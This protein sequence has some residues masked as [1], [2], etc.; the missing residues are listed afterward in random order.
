MS[1]LEVAAERAAKVLPEA[2]AALVTDYLWDVHA[3]GSSTAI[4]DEVMALPV[5]AEF[6]V[7]ADDG[8]HWLVHEPCEGSVRHMTAGDTLDSL[9]GRAGLHTCKETS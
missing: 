4:A 5:P 2:I 9:T 8:Y 3:S 1:P 6:Y 7:N